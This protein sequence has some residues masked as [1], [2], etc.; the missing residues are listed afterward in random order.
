MALT[1]WLLSGGALWAQAEP[2]DYARKRAFFI[3]FSISSEDQTRIREVQLYVSD[4]QGRSWRLHS[5]VGPRESRFSFQAERD[6]DYWFL[7]R[8][9]DV[10]G[11]FQPPT[12]DGQR[13]GLRVIVDTT[14]PAILLH[15]LPSAGDQ[16]GVQWDIREEN[17]DPSTVRL[18]YRGGG[19]DWQPVH[20]EPQV[21]GRKYWTPLGRPP[22]EVRMRAQDRSGNSNTGTAMIGLGTMTGAGPVP[23]Q[24]ARRETFTSVGGQPAVLYVNSLE[25]NLNYKVE[26]EGPSGIDKVELYY[27]RDGRTWQRYGENPTKQSPFRVRLPSDGVYGLSLVIRSGVGLGDPPPRTGDQPQLWVELD[28][29]PP[30]VKLLSAEASRGGELATLNIQWTATDKNLDTQPITISYSEH[31]SGPWTPIA[32]N[33]DNTGRYVWTVPTGA[34]HRFYLRV[35][36]RDKAR[37]VGYAESRQPIIVD[38][39]QPRGIPIGIEPISNVNPAVS[40]V[41]PP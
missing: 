4:N 33:L 27:T 23:S 36:A 24:D 38:L 18:E 15:P 28:L 37:N 1:A 25:F 31:N 40:P 29:K 12:L 9:L 6:G 17:L 39:K 5:S 20:I 2:V 13:P 26:E 8:T 19:G 22:F 16:I 11:Q 41:S 35:E 14:P 7:V 10:T 21:Y 34:P 30:D 32:E 3:P